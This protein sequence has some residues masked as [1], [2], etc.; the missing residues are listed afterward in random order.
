MFSNAIT[1]GTYHTETGAYPGQAYDPYA[2]TATTYTPA[3]AVSQTTYATQSSTPSTHDAYRPD[4]HQSSGSYFPP[5][6]HAAVETSFAALNPAQSPSYTREPYAA[7]PYVSGQPTSQAASISS[8]PNMTPASTA[9]AAPYRPK[10][11]NAYDPPLPPPKAPKFNP[12][13]FHTRPISTPLTPTFDHAPA[14]SPP[15]PRRNIPKANGSLASTD[16]Q[17]AAHLVSQYENRTDTTSSMHR[18]GHQG[19]E[20]AASTAGSNGPSLAEGAKAHIAQQQSPFEGHHDATSSNFRY[21]MFHPPDQP[22]SAFPHVQAVSPVTANIT[23]Y[24]QHGMRNGGTVAEVG[25]YG[26]DRRPYSP[27]GA[28]IDG[29][30]MSPPWVSPQ[31]G[32]STVPG[33]TSTPVHDPYQPAQTQTYDPPRMSSPER[34]RSPQKPF[35]SQYVPHVP[36]GVVQHGT[37]KHGTPKHSPERSKSPGTLSV[38]STSSATGQSVGFQRRQGSFGSSVSPP[39]S[40]SVY[41]PRVASPYE[42][43]AWANV[44][45]STS[46]AASIGSLRNSVIHEGYQ[47]THPQ[48]HT[49]TVSIESSLSSASVPH[50]P[51]APSVQSRRSTSDTFSYVDNFSTTSRP[52]SF[53]SDGHSL[54]SYG[55][56]PSGQILHAPPQTHTTYAPSPSLLGTNDPLGRTAARAPVISFG[57]GGRLIT[58]FHGAGSLNTGFDVALASRQ[59]T[60]LKMYTLYKVIPESALATSTASYP[61][62][63][64]ADPGTP[65]TS[66]VRT[67]SAAQIKSKKARVIKYLEE[68][69]EELSA[70]IGYLHQGS[71]ERLRAEAKRSLVALLKVMVENDGRLSG[72]SVKVDSTSIHTDRATVSKLT[73]LSVQAFCLI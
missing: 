12:G 17:Q 57:A 40:H 43:S 38:R 45:R 11:N 4:T 26:S 13:S 7:S 52:Q 56:Q 71:I 22:L 18:V 41:H 32:S 2:P 70:G 25:G 49:R 39:P 33:S 14:A 64:F 73:R 9:S 35:T 1:S 60:D 65:T 54:R 62:P 21:D 55:D 16:P 23:E 34:T 5:G 10:T 42:P 63:L 51:Y 72:R 48:A 3:A 66:L 20:P 44:E 30:S 68:R 27:Q 69:I 24:A 47:P 28:S 50:D 15:P 46:P 61:G 58:C 53:G 29:N 19:W 8:F 6:S 59:S 31:L 67:G 36:N 37:P